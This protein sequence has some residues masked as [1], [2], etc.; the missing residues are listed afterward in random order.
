MATM[1]DLTH[2]LIADV[3]TVTDAGGTTTTDYEQIRTRWAA[4]LNPETNAAQRLAAAIIEGGETDLLYPLALAEQ[5]GAQT[6]GDVR[7]QVAEQVYPALRNEADKTARANYDTLRDQFNE[8]AAKLIETLSAVDP[9]ARAE[10]L[11]TAPTKARQAW[12]DAPIHAA[13]LNAQLNALK[14]A[15]KLAG[16]TIGTNDAYLALSTDPGNT[17]RRRV[18]E[19]WETTEGRAGRW[20]ALHKLGVKIGAPDLD[21]Y[22]PYRRPVELETRYK[23]GLHGHVP[24][25]VDPEDMPTQQAA[26]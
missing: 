25:I 22:K 9:D 14:V 4:L 7:N 26:S 17:H 18:W 3:K 15:A 23:A 1:I 13:E 10:D 19:A 8:T 5:A 11:M 12:A 21:N 16:A 6:V 20:A 2:A 24:Y